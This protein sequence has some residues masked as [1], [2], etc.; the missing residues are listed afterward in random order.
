MEQFGPTQRSF[1]SFAIPSLM[2]SLLV[3]GLWVLNIALDSGGHFA[4]KLAAVE[5]DAEASGLDH[6]RHMLGRPWLWLGVFCFIGEFVV[7]L[8][9]LSVVP[10]AQGVLLGMISIVVVMLAGR[11]VFH[12]HFTRPRIIGML[13]IVGGVAIVGAG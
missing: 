9:F 5:P 1:Q 12:E 3:F 8:A 10:L 4:F 7:W 2:K 11:I 6:W 13:L